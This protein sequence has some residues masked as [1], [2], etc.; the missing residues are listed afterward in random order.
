MIIFHAKKRI[1]IYSTKKKKIDKINILSST[2]KFT[3]YTNY[4]IGLI[5]IR[6]IN[7]NLREH[8]QQTKMTHYSNFVAE[9]FKT[10]CEYCFCRNLISTRGSHNLNSHIFQVIS[11]VLWDDDPKLINNVEI[12]LFPSLISLI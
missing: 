8:D 12:I 10:K 4:P 3:V 2:R 11:T 5:T 7:L 1:F 6:I 9:N